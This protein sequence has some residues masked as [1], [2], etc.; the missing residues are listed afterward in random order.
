MVR[1]FLAAI[2]SLGLAFGASAQDLISLSIPP[3]TAHSQVSVV[4]NKGLTRTAKLPTPALRD[5]RVAMIAGKEISVGAL[6]A[7]ADH[8]DGLA[9]QKY[10]RYLL[11]EVPD[12][13]ASDIAYYGAIAV[14][15]G[16]G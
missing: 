15:T 13:S 5:A 2:L 3:D 10:V 9:A 12:A 6:K 1:S 16:G 4:V 11:A 8:W 14:S 7:L